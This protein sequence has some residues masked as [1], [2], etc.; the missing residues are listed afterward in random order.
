MVRVTKLGL[1]LGEYHHNLTEKNRIALPKRI[2]VEIEGFEV[3]LSRGAEACIEGFD[4]S[5]WKE[6]VRQQLAIPFHEEE[7]RRVRRRIFSSAMIVEVDSQG[8]VVLPDP[9]LSWSGLK[10]KVGE[11]VVVIGVG[12]HF[13]IW[14]SGNWNKRLKAPVT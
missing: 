5:Q 10:G 7:G 4:K 6:L 2:R 13:E 3:V 14:E 1:F 8:R 11:E 9:L 12:D